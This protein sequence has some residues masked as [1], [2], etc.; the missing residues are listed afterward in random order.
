MSQKNRLVKETSPYLQQ[1]A[2]NPVDW[3]AWDPDAL[4]KA[5]DQDKPILLSV[6]YSACHWCHVMAHESFENE[7]TAQLMNDRFINIKVDREERP[8][9]DK[10]YQTAHQ[11]LTRHA[12][13]WPLTIFLTPAGHTP[14]YSGTYFPRESR[15]G[16]PAFSDVLVRVAD[17]YR[18]HKTEL[19]NQ[20]DSV[21]EAFENLN[22]SPVADDIELSDEPLRQAR[23]QLEQDFDARFGGFGKAPKFP[24]ATSIDRLLQHWH[25][26]LVTNEPDLKALYMAS[27]TLRRMGHGGIYDQLGGGFCRYSVDDYWM[28]PHF[29]KMLYDNGQ[30]LALYAQAVLATGEP[31]YHRIA[32]GVAR[33]VM[34]EMQGPDGAYYATLDADSDGAEGRYY[35]WD[36]DEIKK[37][38]SNAEYQVLERRFGLDRSPNFEDQWHL[39]VHEQAAHVSTMLDLTEDEVRARLESAR[40]RLLEVRSQRNRPARDEKVITGWNGLMIRGMAIAARALD[41]PDLLESAVRAADFLQRNLWQNGRLLAV[42]KD[43]RARFPA[44]LDDYA[45]L[46]DG[47]IELLQSRWHTPTFDWCL[48]L[49]A[50]MI[51]HFE[52]PDAGGFFFTADDHEQLL[53]RPKT[54]GDD[55]TP[56]GNGIAAQVL[57]RL[58]S[59]T[60]D[61]RY[62]TARERTLRAGWSAMLRV[63]QAHTSLLTALSDMLTAAEVV[64]IRGDGNEFEAW[65]KRVSRLYAPQRLVLAIRS[66]AQ[67]L[68][69]CLAIRAASA[70]TVAYVC[71]GSEC[72]MPILSADDLLRDLGVDTSA[73]DAGCAE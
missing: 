65:H 35:V 70:E 37:I 57:G 71:R 42:Y 66:T 59:I 29:E 30:L 14:F 12:G 39:H 5:R 18:D 19:E 60:G 20:T 1:H 73:G 49:A 56:S 64:I 17:F 23:H 38:V 62:A 26:T 24:H 7:A 27:L 69:E 45:N 67:E 32:E 3:H 52:D 63:P 34:A 41:R 9:I 13:G 72:S 51:D 54:F 10:I 4:E 58:W 22:P 50:V 31:L 55:A 28:I 16:L 2:D 47:L 43:G 61:S 6:G 25:G 11:L 68:P 48:E 15:H 53:C 46:L 21:R 36:K 40:R 33:W 8:D 44:Y